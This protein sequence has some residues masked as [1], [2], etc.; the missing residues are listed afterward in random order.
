MKNFFD[1]FKSYNFWISFVGVLII[2]LNAF[3]KIFGFSIENR[4]IEECV[5]SVAGI[6][7]GLG[8]VIKDDNKEEG[9][10]E[11]DIFEEEHEKLN[12]DNNE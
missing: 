12:D 6:L 4:I 8:I 11:E 5:I 10:G 9:E 2:V 7:V 1:K 3:G